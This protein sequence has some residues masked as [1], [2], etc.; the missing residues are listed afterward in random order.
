MT[1]VAL[2]IVVIIGTIGLKII[3]GHK[4]TLGECAYHAFVFISTVDRP[5]GGEPDFCSCLSFKILT[6]FLLISGMGTILYGVS[7]ITAFIVEGELTDA[8]RR[9]RMEKKIGELR[10]HIIVCGVGETGYYIVEELSRIRVPFVVVETSEERLERIKKLHGSLYINGD[11]T[12]D[13]VLKKAG[14]DH[15]A[16]V[17]LAL[18]GDKDNLFAT[19][20]T[21]QFSP[22]IK[23]V[24]KCT[25]PRTDDKFVRAGADKVVSPAAIGALRLVSEMVRPSVVTFLDRML[26]DPEETTRIEEM[27]IAEGGNLADKTLSEARLGDQAGVLVLAISPPEENKFIYRPSPNTKL[28]PGTLV[29]IIGEV[30]SIAKARNLAGTA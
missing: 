29:V 3:A 24:V 23:I 10:K 11:A 30:D 15:A 13:N 1:L 9:R 18:P 4:A 12:D 22:H 25:D 20:T 16:G 8:L 21:R 28:T 26:R 17:I 5:F 27:T 14:I 19:V 7:T 6:V 2:V